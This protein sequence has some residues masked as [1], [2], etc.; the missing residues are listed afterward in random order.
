MS[1]L[2]E[3]SNHRLCQEARYQCLDEPYLAPQVVAKT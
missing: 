1:A 3:F 2:D